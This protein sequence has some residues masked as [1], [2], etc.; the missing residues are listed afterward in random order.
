MTALVSINLI[1]HRDF[2]HIYGALRSLFETTAL[3]P[4]EVQ[5]IIN[6]GD[7][8]EVERLR[9]AFPDVT[10][11]VNPQPLGFAAN[12]NAFMRTAQTPYVALLNDDLTLHAGALDAMIAYMEAHPRVG[13][14]GAALLN[15]DGTPQVSV[16]GDPRL[17]LTLY[18]ISGL[19]SLTAEGTALR[20][21]LEKLNRG[22]VIKVESWVEQ[23][24]TRKVPVVKGAVMVVRRAAYEE[25]GL[26][27]E[28]TRVYGEEIDWHLR[29]RRAGWQ[30]VMIAE[31]KITHHGIGQRITLSNLV[32]DRAALLNYYLKHRPRWQGETVRASLIAFHGLRA[33]AWLPFDRTRSAAHL[34][35][36]R[37]ARAWRVADVSAAADRAGR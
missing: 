2:T 28:S 30:V 11:V 20:R 6:V 18:K 4:L 25:V 8:A 36:V 9:Q 24:R 7:P 5:V 14:A 19:S 22:R 29:F 21:T 13:L 1:V 15:P 31:A 32:E 34:R 27:D 35:V 33:A 10:I 37:M 23:A 17:P 16:Y 26:M 12:H 3:R